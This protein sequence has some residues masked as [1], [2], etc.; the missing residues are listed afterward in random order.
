MKILITGKNGFISKN[1]YQKLKNNLKYDIVFLEKN[2]S[3]TDF[4]NNILNADIIFHLAG[5]SRSNNPKTFYLNNYEYTK[6]I[7]SILK[8]SKKKIKII[9]SSSSKNNQNIV[10]SRS[11]LKAEKE[12][13][14]LR[15][16]NKNIQLAL[17]RLPNI[18][19][20][21][22]KPFYNSVVAT[23][24]HQASRNHTLVVKNNKKLTLV[25]IDDLVNSFVK[26][27]KKKK[28]KKLFYYSSPQYQISVKD[29][30]RKIKSFFCRNVCDI[31][32]LSTGLTK[33]LY[34][35]YLSFTPT[36]KKFLNIKV[37]SD[38]RGEFMEFKKSKNFGQISIVNIFPKKTR[39][40]HYHNT[41]IERFLVL[42]GK[43]KFNFVNILNTKKKYSIICSEKYPQIILTKPGW[44]HN[45]KN[46]GSKK[47]SIVIWSNEIFDKKNPDTYSYQV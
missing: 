39:G 17:F 8:N 6:K 35:T 18:F 20:K 27:I 16:R 46:I 19:G 22:S 30:A 33:K 32:K 21:W 11:K 24:C 7:C 28:F 31:E 15:R 2:S 10:Y 25:Y 1:L 29:L 12:L 38:E 37:N 43:V 34:S 42:V 41:K 44:A 5:T 4:K 23:F 36:S 13:I 14:I 40:N 3:L 26:I 47:A 9:Y 45:V